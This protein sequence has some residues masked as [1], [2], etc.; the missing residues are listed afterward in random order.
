MINIGNAENA[1]EEELERHPYTTYEPRPE[2]SLSPDPIITVKPQ[3]LPSF[4]LH[5]SLSN[6]NIELI[7]Y[8]SGKDSTTFLNWLF[9][10]TM[11]TIATYVA[12]VPGEGEI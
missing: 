3:P 12:K 10:L 1:I 5:Q 2:S 6:L 11:F 7:D 8:G 4:G 9:K